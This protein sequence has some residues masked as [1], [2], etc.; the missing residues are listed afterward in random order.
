[1]KTTLFTL[2][3]LLLSTTL[4][5]QNAKR[6]QSN[7]NQTIYY[8]V[9]GSFDSLQKA[10]DFNNNGPADTVF[11]N[12]YKC[13][14]NGKTVYRVCSGCFYNKAKAQK[15]ARELHDIYKEIGWDVNAWVYPN[16]GLAVCVDRGQ[17]GDGNYFSTKPE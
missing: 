4:V 9:V 6:N 1:M 3:M 17:G 2:I 16:K 14:A 13:T 8:V 11:G 7:G 5:A 12:V 10:K 15:E